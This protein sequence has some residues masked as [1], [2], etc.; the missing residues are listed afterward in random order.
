MPVGGLCTAPRVLLES[1]GLKFFKLQ[2]VG[3]MTY[4]P[5]FLPESSGMPESGRTVDKIWRTQPGLSQESCRLHWK[6]HIYTSLTPKPNP[7]PNL[8]PNLNPNPN[9]NPNQQQPSRPGIAVQ[10]GGV[11]QIPLESGR[12]HQTPAKSGQFRQNPAE[13]KYS[14]RVRRILIGQVGQCKVL[15]SGC[16]K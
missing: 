3:F 12:L 10:L 2:N 16:Q 7:R 11:Q 15:A 6:Q 5:T 1:A 8:N 4:G 9:P 14:A 13:K